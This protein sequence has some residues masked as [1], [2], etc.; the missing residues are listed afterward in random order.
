MN[1]EYRIR[2][3]R[4]FGRVLSWCRF[5]YHFAPAMSAIRRTSVRCGYLLQTQLLQRVRIRVQSSAILCSRS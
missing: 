2:Q 1:T 4:Q 5:S 3:Y